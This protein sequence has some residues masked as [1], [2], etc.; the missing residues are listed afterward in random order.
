MDRDRNLHQFIGCGQFFDWLVRDLE[1]DWK[2][3][4]KEIWDRPL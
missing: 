1:H 2:T 3:D 4:G